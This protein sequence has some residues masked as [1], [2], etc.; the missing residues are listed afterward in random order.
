VEVGVR[1]RQRLRV[2][3]LEVNRRSFG[4]CPLPGAVEER[5]HEVDRRYVAVSARRHQSRVAA[6]A[7]DVEDALA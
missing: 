3:L 5:R 4:G 1:V 2:A 7:R 6:S